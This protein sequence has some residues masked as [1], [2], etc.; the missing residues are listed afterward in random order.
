MNPQ[1]PSAAT[2][3]A[4]PDSRR[5]TYTSNGVGS[6]AIYC[7][8]NIAIN[9]ATLTA[10]GSEAVCIEGLNSLHLFDCDLSGNMSD[11]DQNDCTWGVIVYQSM[12]GDSEVGNSTFQ[13][14]GGKLST[15]NRRSALHHQHRVYTDPGQRGYHLRS[16]QRI[17]SPLHRQQ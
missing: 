12:S 10:N 14:T 4:A 16:G 9:N 6:P 17:L 1:L 13:M 8:A 11:D 5:R 15:G 3:A 2:A 7:T